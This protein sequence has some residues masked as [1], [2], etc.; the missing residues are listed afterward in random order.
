[1]EA[2]IEKRLYKMFGEDENFMMEVYQTI[3]EKLSKNPTDTEIR[4]AVGEEIKARSH[5]S[6]TEEYATDL[7]AS[8]AQLRSSNRLGKVLIVTEDKIIPE[9]TT[10][11]EDLDETVDIVQRQERVTKSIQEE[12]KVIRNLIKTRDF[13]GNPRERE[14]KIQDFVN[15]LMQPDVLLIKARFNTTELEQMSKAIL[16]EIE[17]QKLS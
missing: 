16:A 3:R 7:L 6:F 11:N 10:H 4:E 15:L 9:Y 5:T 17:R 1:M 14:R 13:R 12:R 8:L 2:R